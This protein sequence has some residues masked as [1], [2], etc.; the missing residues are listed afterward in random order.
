MPGPTLVLMPW[1][2]RRLQRQLRQTRDARVYRRTLAVLRVAAGEA[3][4]DV[5]HALGVARRT[6][7][8]WLSGYGREHDPGA[9][10][11]RPRRGRPGLWSEDV[12]AL[13]RELLAGSPQRRGYA[14]ASW[15]VPLLREELRHGTGLALS[16]DTIRRELGREG[17]AWKR[18]RYVLEPDP[19][20]E[21]KTPHPP[22]HR[23]VG[24]ARRRPRPGRD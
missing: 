22:A 17:Y 1:E 24:A 9:L 14:A 8:S 13:L 5:A 20:A 7:H 2:R 23:R 10:C 12:R 4:T 11:D 3:I 6:V 15:T 16:A 21:K 18:P 19:D